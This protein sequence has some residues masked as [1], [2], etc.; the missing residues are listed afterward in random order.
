MKFKLKKQNQK[1]KKKKTDQFLAS[2]LSDEPAKLTIP[3]NTITYHNTL[4]LSR[5]NFFI[6]I[7][8]EFLSGV[9][10]APRPAGGYSWEYL[11]GVCRPVLQNPDP[12][13]D[14]KVFPQPFSDQTSRIHTRFQ[15]ERETEK[16]LG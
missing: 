7:V 8:F 9:K 10:T 14:Q 5:Q 16:S 13:S 2:P 1:S 4:C 11:V 3:E 12:I 6:S 15:T